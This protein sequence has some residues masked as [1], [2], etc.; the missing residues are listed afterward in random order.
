MRKT[1]KKTLLLILLAI[2][3]LSIV[4]STVAI[5]FGEENTLKGSNG[6]LISSNEDV[7]KIY[8][9]TNGNITVDG[10]FT[11][12]YWVEFEKQFKD[13]TCGTDG[14]LKT[15]NFLASELEKLGVEKYNGSYLQNFSEY[16]DN[17]DGTGTLLNSQN[18]VGV[19]K[20]KNV[21]AKQ[22]VIGAHYDN[23]YGLIENARS[24]G[25]YDN[26]SGVAS[27]I[28]IAKVLQDFEFDF[29]IVY[30]FF[31]M[32]EIGLFGSSA[33][34]NKMSQVQKDNTILMINFDSTICGDYLYAYTDELP[35]LHEDLFFE[36]DKELNLNALR[37]YPKDKKA[38]LVT[39]GDRFFMHTGQMSDN[40]PFLNAKINA[41][42]FTGYNLESDKIVGVLE[43]EGETD[44]MHTTNDNVEKILKL[45]GEQF[46]TKRFSDS[47]SVVL[48][49]LAK[50]NFQEVM[51]QSAEENNIPYFVYGKVFIG[52]TYGV[53]LVA[54]V[55]AI[56]LTVRKLQKETV[57]K[58][59]K[60]DETIMQEDIF[61]TFEEI[62][63]ASPN[64]QQN[65][66]KD[67]DDDDIFGLK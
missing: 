14:E 12:N 61:K 10:E 46:V 31:G 54:F 39:A 47:I 1:M 26:A 44:I 51:I 28:T 55:L 49:T 37:K 21:N 27:V 13:R 36:S 11:F 60:S 65:Q 17:G 62:K 25:A 22:V 50:D 29:D 64:A 57:D 15:A 23:S 59:G 66:K 7:E 41:I 42:S 9:M 6:L 16:S 38:V 34:V 32:E 33:F 8:S 48:S 52:I 43:K 4:F 67:N 24:E 35:R 40:F 20:S 63:N 19:K 3:C 18:V 53:V 45:Y 30:A 2:I 5:A 56:F 58:T